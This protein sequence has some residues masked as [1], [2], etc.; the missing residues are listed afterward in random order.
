MCSPPQ[1][2]WTKLQA[3]VLNEIKQFDK[4][5]LAHVET[6]IKHLSGATTTETVELQVRILARYG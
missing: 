1:R 3:A 4:S 5:K 2:G 6:T